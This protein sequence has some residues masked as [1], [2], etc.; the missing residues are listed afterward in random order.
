MFETGSS[1]CPGNERAIE[2][3]SMKRFAIILTV[4]KYIDPNITELRYAN[5][6]GDL[7]GNLFRKICRFDEV[8]IL[9]TDTSADGMPNKATLIAHLDEFAQK[10]KGQEVL[11]VFF[12][13]GHGVE[14]SSKQY[15]MLGD[16]KWRHALTYLSLEDLISQIQSLQAKQCVYLI[17]ACRNSPE[18]T[19]GNEDNFLND[20]FTR[21]LKRRVE[22]GRHTEVSMIVTACRAGERAYECHESHQGVFTAGLSKGIRHA[23]AT[24]NGRFHPAMRIAKEYT[25]SWSKKEHG[26]V[27]QTPTCES[28]GIGDEIRLIDV[29]ETTGN[30]PIPTDTY[31][32]SPLSDFE[33]S[34]AKENVDH[35][36]SKNKGKLV[37][38]VTATFAVAV[39]FILLIAHLSKPPE[40]SQ[41]AKQKGDNGS[42]NTS[43]TPAIS[44]HPLLISGVSMPAFRPFLSS[45]PFENSLQMPFV[46]IPKLNRLMCLWETRVQDFE[47]FVDDSFGVDASWKQRLNSPQHP[48]VFVNLKDATAFCEWLT[49]RE[50]ASGVLPM[51]AY[52][53][54]QTCYDYDFALRGES[55]LKDAN[56]ASAL[57]DYLKNNEAKED[58]SLNAKIHR[59]NNVGI[60]SPV[61][62]GDPNS[63]GFVFLGGNVF[64]WCLDALPLGGEQAARQEQIF[65]PYRQVLTGVERVED[66]G[67]RIVIDFMDKK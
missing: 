61:N 10:A 22:S 1:I 55:K 60:S 59:G 42:D 2:R 26:K 47:A 29:G 27:L 31:Y 16:A 24:E 9:S 44:E 63:S 35:G 17:D 53:R 30:A 40:A 66:H 48:V 56:R 45:D 51:E 18:H 20:T 19:R 65:V 7:V 38:Y 12:F 5:A 21:E 6:D 36:S 32:K 41:H 52:Y 39:A 50:H 37:Y 15:L 13:A 33:S 58:A 64:E 14:L 54:V 3:I 62:F 28:V 25:T 11:F 23:I 34:T 43:P 67:F 57:I 8:R 4:E 49:K 46:R